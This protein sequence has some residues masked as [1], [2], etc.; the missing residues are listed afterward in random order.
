[1]GLLTVEIAFVANPYGTLVWTDVT[2]KVDALS[3]SRGRNYELGKT[4]AGT[5]T[6]TLRNLD[7]RFDPSNT[8]SPYY[9]YVLPYRPIRISATYLGTTYRLWYGFIE[10]WPQR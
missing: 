4:E 5:A 1:M 3:C 9:P 2:N 10:R 8:T 7:G 6:I